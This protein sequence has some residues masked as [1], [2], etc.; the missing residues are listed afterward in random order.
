[1]SR[2]KRGTGGRPKKRLLMAS[3]EVQAWAQSLPIPPLHEVDQ[4]RAAIEDAERQM[5]AIGAAAGWP[6]ANNRS[7]PLDAD[8]DTIPRGTRRNL[9]QITRWHQQMRIRLCK[10]S[11]VIQPM[12]LNVGASFQADAAVVGCARCAIRL[13]KM[14]SEDPIEDYT[15]DGCRV[16]RPEGLKQTM[17]QMGAIIVTAGYCPDCQL[18]EVTA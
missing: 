12:F 8:A 5:Q 9:D 11:D 13:H 2:K 10:H 4:V 18:P 15:C 16:H 14:I 3:P 7:I 1:M 17:I 6:D